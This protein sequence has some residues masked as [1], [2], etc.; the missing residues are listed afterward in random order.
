LLHQL[1]QLPSET[2]L[3]EFKKNK[4]APDEI[5]ENISALA[6]SAALLDADFAYIAWGVENSTHRIVGTVFAPSAE[7]VGNENLENWL[8]HLLSPRINFSF[9]KF[10]AEGQPVVLLKIPR[11]FPYPVQWKGQVYI[12]VGSYTKKLK[13]FPA[14]EQ[15]LWRMLDRRTFETMVAIEHATDDDVLRL[16]DY[17]KFF[18]LIKIPL[19]PN[20]DQILTSLE[21]YGLLGRSEAGSWNVMNLGAILFAKKLDAFPN[22]ARKAVRVIS[23]KQGGRITGQT[24]QVENS[25]YA[26]GFENLIGHITALVPPNEIMGKALRRTLPM[27]PTLA[28]RELV[29]NALIH[30]DFSV[31]GAGPTIEIFA[32]RMEI[33]NPGASL[34]D[35][36]RLLDSAPRSRNE[37][38]AALMRKL[39]IC[40]ER[41]SGIDKVVFEIEYYQLPPALFELKG[42]ATA[43]TLFAYQPLSKMEKGARIRACYQHACL[44]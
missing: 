42:D 6:N 35:P 31:T 5:G 10:E 26:S 38:L 27:Y 22:L 20:K 30:Q 4:C 43:A 33:T 11:A 2:E 24:E 40:E 18:D 34:V 41:G 36:D 7:K 21:Q 37:K 14:K 39:G 3:V 1:R 8:S 44:R 28:V 15:Q 9:H 13:D 19:P 16:I 23:Y 17:P 12:R 29:A 32:D 25:G